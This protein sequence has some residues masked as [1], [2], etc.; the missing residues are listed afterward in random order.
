LYGEI[1]FFDRPK[2]WWE[3]SLKTNYLSRNIRLLQQLAKGLVS[4]RFKQLAKESKLSRF[5]S[6]VVDP[7]LLVDLNLQVEREAIQL[8]E[9]SLLELVT[10]ERLKAEL[11]RSAARIQKTFDIVYRDE[12]DPDANLFSAENLIQARMKC[13]HSRVQLYNSFLTVAEDVESPLELAERAFIKADRFAKKLEPILQADRAYYE[14][15]VRTAPQIHRF[16]IK[17]QSDSEIEKQEALWGE[18]QMEAFKSQQ[19]LS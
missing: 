2:W 10:S 19:A 1:N 4:E 5:S 13:L 8:A 14:E 16:L 9:I 15:L 11:R 3:K 18:F 17:K 12:E 6:R 7:V